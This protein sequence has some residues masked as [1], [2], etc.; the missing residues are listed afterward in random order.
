MSNV[1]DAGKMQAFDRV[2]Q[3]VNAAM[4]TVNGKPQSAEDTVMR[5]VDGNGN[6]RRV[7]ACTTDSIKSFGGKWIR[8]GA[9]KHLN[10]E[11]RNDFKESL[12]EFLGKKGFNDIKENLLTRGAKGDK[13]IGA[14]IYEALESDNFKNGGHPLSARRILNVALAAG[15]VKKDSNGKYVKGNV[16]KVSSGCSLA[17][18]LQKIIDDPVARHEAAARFRASGGI[19][20]FDKA[21]VN[22]DTD[23]AP[24]TTMKKLSLIGGD[25]G[26]VAERLRKLGFKGNFIIVNFA[27]CTWMGGE[28][29]SGAGTQEEMVYGRMNPDFF[30]FLLEEG[31]LKIG[32]DSATRKVSF[33]YAKPLTGGF[34]TA[35][36]PFLSTFTLKEE[37]VEQKGNQNVPGEVKP[38]KPKEQTI[39]NM[40][41]PSMSNEDTGF[42]RA[43]YASRIIGVRKN[44]LAQDYDNDHEDDLNKIKAMP[45]GELKEKGLDFYN[46]P[47]MGYI[48]RK[49]KITPEKEK[50]ILEY[51]Q[52]LHISI[53]EKFPGKDNDKAKELRKIVQF[54]GSQLKGDP[55]GDDYGKEANK[56]IDHAVKIYDAHKKALEKGV[57]S[58][59][60]KEKALDAIYQKTI[61]NYEKAIYDEYATA[62]IRMRRAGAKVCPIGLTG[63]GAFGN[64]PGPVARMA[65]MAFR[66]FGGD[67]IPVLDIY[68]LFDALGEVDELKGNEKVFVEQFVKVFNEELDKQKTPK[69]E[70]LT[71]EDFQGEAKLKVVA[72]EFKTENPD[73]DDNVDVQQNQASVQNPKSLLIEEEGE[74]GEIELGWNKPQVHIQNH[75][76]Q[77]IEGDVDEN[78]KFELIDNNLHGNNVKTEPLQEEEGVVQT[79][80]DEIKGKMSTVIEWSDVNLG[81][82]GKIEDSKIGE[83]CDKL[84]NN[85]EIVKKST[86]DKEQKT[87]L[88]AGGLRKLVAELFLRDEMIVDER[89]K[90]NIEKQLEKLGEIV[91]KFLGDEEDAQ[92]EGVKKL[93]NML[94]MCYQYLQINMA[95]KIGGN[96]EIKDSHKIETQTKI[97]ISLFISKLK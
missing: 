56:A 52:K 26:L 71:M 93:K 18:D 14:K 19:T 74:N 17:S 8:S 46:V 61:T 69:N 97:N 36:D 13:R 10:N 38:Q 63:C 9:E 75:G 35:S 65:A 11:T 91:E 68:H 39:I 21:P 16:G 76:S 82:T 54:A 27:D 40:A 15:L 7:E 67:M 48:E 2:M 78:G 32:F 23:K 57:D 66:D 25:M 72:K 44:E 1:N 24:C 43:N 77:L 92:K 58:L 50:T 87:E 20:K 34:S 96:Q 95:D 86:L 31:L 59:S 22:L 37:K 28:M 84:K 29:T 70:L 55:F 64:K 53:L 73:V 90:A 89:Y 5:L 94:H 85:I 45:D 51:T 79:L 81:K 83:A 12:L 33:E 49:L 42:D 6:N 41:M 88:L 80:L 62:I 47:K 30:A 4:D 60:A 3:Y